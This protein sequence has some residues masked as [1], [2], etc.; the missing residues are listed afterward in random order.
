MCVGVPAKVIKKDEF[1]AEVDVLGSQ[2]TVGIIFVPEVELG[3]Y[4]IVHA[5]QAM[6]IVDEEYAK[7][8]VEEWMKLVNARS[9]ETV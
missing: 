7:Q 6:S 2:T 5:G 9:S 1:S 3:D 8:S 4:V